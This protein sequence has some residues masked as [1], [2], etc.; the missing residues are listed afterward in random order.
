VTR[1]QRE[2]R[3]LTSFATGAAAH[4]QEHHYEAND[5][6][7]C[8][9]NDDVSV[10][11]NRSEPDNPFVHHDND[12]QKNSN[13][14]KPK[15]TTAHESSSSLARAS[16]LLTTCGRINRVSIAALRIIVNPTMGENT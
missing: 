14:D 1:L 15:A 13:N 2:A 5:S 4:A 10:R 12:S 9:D 6:Y 8:S 7:D 11:V 16:N 3:Q